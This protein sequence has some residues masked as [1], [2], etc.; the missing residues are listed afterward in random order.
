MPSF[1]RENRIG[2]FS[3]YYS[4]SFFKSVGLA[5]LKYHFLAKKNCEFAR[6]M[7]EELFGGGK[8]SIY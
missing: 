8:Q 7:L 5:L 2:I 6:N 4:L 3:Q 1:S